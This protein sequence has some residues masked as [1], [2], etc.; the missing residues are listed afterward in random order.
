MFIVNL[1]N[2]LADRKKKKKPNQGKTHK[3]EKEKRKEKE[4]KK[5][6][7]GMMEE[8]GLKYIPS[9]RASSSEYVPW[10]SSING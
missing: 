5:G 2:I 4:K 3:K 1:I 6:G 9:E 8:A 10:S 7:K